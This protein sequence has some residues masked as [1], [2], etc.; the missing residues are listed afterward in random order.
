MN[1]L[2]RNSRFARWA[3]LALGAT[4][5]GALVLAPGTAAAKVE[6]D[7]I[8]LGAAVSLTGKYSTNGKNTKDGYDLAVARINEMGGVKV[9]GKAYRLKIIY[10]DDESTSAR[11]AQLAER[12][13]GQDGVKF[14]LGPYSS[15]LTKAI[16]PVT[17][18]YR[19]P[20]VEGNGADRSLFTQGYRYLFAVLNTSDYYLRAA[21][22]LAA[23]Q[24][25][26]AGRDP[27]SLKVAIAIEND[28]FSQDVRNGV[29]EDA[30][31]Y[32]MKVI[33]D[34]KLPPEINDMAPTLAKVKAL[35]PDI[36]VVSGHAKGAALAVKQVADM[37]VDVPMLALTHCDSAQIIEKFGKAAEH[38]VCASQWDRSLAYQDKWF[39]SAEDYAKRFAATFN[40]EPPYQAAESTASVLVYVDAIERAQSFD[41]EKVRDAIA[42]TDLM[43]FYGP[44]KFDAAG[45]N[46]AKSMVLYQV[47]NGD[48]K[49]VAPSAWAQSRVIYP[50]PLW[51]S[52]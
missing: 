3:A 23:E 38:A 46:I 36:L 42:A 8:V 49:V 32:G 11:G 31:K 20:M 7:T 18:K 17:E 40:Y 39:G 5:A 48:F 13:I 30:A 19:I 4:I 34:D 10:Y 12:L 52:R 15:G 29:A 16:A 45:R 27:A 26:K 44:V 21:V 41:P 47:Q 9:G 51:A 25:K 14:V 6:G 50:A 35:K 37:K 33:I 24:A 43:T 28:D 2:T 1:N 22:E